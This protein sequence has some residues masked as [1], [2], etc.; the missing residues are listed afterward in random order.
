MTLRSM[1]GY[2]T[3]AAE[4]E[5]LRASVSIRALN[6]RY[7]E[8]TQQLPR[9]LQALESEIRSRVQSRIA[10]G[11]VEVALRAS[12]RDGEG[13]AVHASRPLAAGLVRV[14]REMQTEYGLEGGVHVA[15]LA[16]FPGVLET[17]E[18]PAAEGPWR[19]RIL[20]LVEAALDGVEDMRK[21]EGGKLLEDL[22]GRLTAVEAA[23]GRL[24]TLAE[25]TRASR[26]EALREKL[27][28]LVAELGLDEGR[29]YQEVVRQVER[30]EFSEE[31]QRLRSHVALARG[32]LGREGPC[33][34]R[35]DFLAQELAREANTIGS[36]AASAALVHEVVALKGE[37]E[38]FRE[39]V[40]N[41]E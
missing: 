17:V 7:L 38:R 41:V 26:S 28:G 39:Q 22:A 27:R 1:T 3:A 32:L 33:G 19:E 25:S 30:S 8:I 15:D 34:K 18:E 4:A 29:L 20:A 24:E 10:R 12:L 31:L 35:L 23:A 13:E 14:L 6:H 37:I 40:Q 36:K 2:G 16:R 21:A 5:D 11:K 9:R